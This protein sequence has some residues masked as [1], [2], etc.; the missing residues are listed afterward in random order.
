MARVGRASLA[1]VPQLTLIQFHR[2]QFNAVHTEAASQGPWNSYGPFCLDRTTN[3][4]AASSANSAEFRSLV[5]CVCVIHGS[6]E[7]HTLPASFSHRE[8]H[9]SRACRIVQD[10]NLCKSQSRCSLHCWL[11]C[12]RILRTNMLLGTSALLVVASALLV[13]TRSY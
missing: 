1:N 11:G 10:P 4:L 5:K 3:M 13:V 9:K 8:F 7:L 12:A 2:C 6:V